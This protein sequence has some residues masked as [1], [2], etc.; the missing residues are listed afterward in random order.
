MRLISKISAT[1][2]YSKTF[3]LIGFFLLISITKI[4]AQNAKEDIFPYDQQEKSATPSFRQRLFF[5]GNFGLQF[6][7]YTDIQISPIVGYWLLPRVAVAA[8][9]TYRYMKD[10]YDRTAV[11]G[12]KGYL[13]FVLIQDMGKVLSGGVHTGVFIHFEDEL[14]SLKTSFWKYPP[15]ESDRFY[16]NTALLGLGISQPLGERASLNFMV[17]W[18]LSESDYEL[19]SKPDIR[20]SFTF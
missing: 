4:L 9:P 17:L 16:L 2:S 12:G 3:L 19:Y 13:Q 15:Y 8:G 5:G 20:V 7:T 14:V 18:P 1:T 10:S 6:G 11:Y